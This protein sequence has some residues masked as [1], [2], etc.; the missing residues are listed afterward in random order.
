MQ[1]GNAKRIA[2][3]A[4]FA[5]LALMLTFVESVIPIQLIV[6]IPGFRLGLANLAIMPVVFFIG[7]VD[8][9]AVAVV[10]VAVSAILFSSPT[11]F[12]YSL[13]GTLLSVIA[14]IILSCFGSKIFSFI[15]ISVICAAFHNLGQILVSVCIFG[16]TSVSILPYLIVVSVISGIVTG[17][18]MMASSKQILQMLRKES[19]DNI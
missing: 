4:S 1:S 8:G 15:G 17:T 11:S 16:I 12:L 6:P 13:T 2:V 5:T 14:L 18:L 10:K 3:C 9:I 7:K 19:G